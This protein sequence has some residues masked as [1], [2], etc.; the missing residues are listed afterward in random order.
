MPA[1]VQVLSANRGISRTTHAII[2]FFL[3]ILLYITHL[4]KLFLHICR[5]LL[6]PVIFCTNNCIIATIPYYLLKAKK[7]A[8]ADSHEYLSFFLH[9]PN[10]FHTLLLLIYFQSHRYSQVH[11]GTCFNAPIGSVADAHF[12]TAD[13]IVRTFIIQVAPFDYLSLL[14]F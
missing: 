10:H 5:H 9:S 13:K 12:T 6:D 8:A 4:D 3:L 11:D 2:H 1:I 14:C 7:P